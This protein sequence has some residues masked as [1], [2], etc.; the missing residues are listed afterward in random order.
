MSS[1]SEQRTDAID[2][3]SINSGDVPTVTAE[4]CAEWRESTI[5]LQKTLAERA[6]VSETTVSYHLAGRCKHEHDE[7]EEEWPPWE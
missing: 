1:D 4:Q 5:P 3:R 7:D 2:A 6:G